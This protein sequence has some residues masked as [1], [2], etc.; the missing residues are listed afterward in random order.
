[1]TITHTSLQIEIDEILTEINKLSQSDFI[2]KYVKNP[3]I[4]VLGLQL[5]NLSLSESSIPKPIR[6][7][8]S[9][10]AGLVQLGID[11]HEKIT[12]LEEKTEYGIR[13][14]QL[15]IL[16]GDYYSS[17]YY[18][19]LAKNNLTDETKKLALA[20]RNI[21]IAK[22]KLY[23]TDSDN[24]FIS[25]D[26]IIELIMI[27][28]SNLYTQFLDEIKDLAQKEVWKSL[29]ENII[30]LFTLTEELKEKNIDKKHLSYH[31]IRNYSN[32]EEKRE[33]SN[34][35]L[36]NELKNH[37]IK[38]LYHKYD[39]QGKLEG[40]I[41]NINNELNKKI[42]IIEDRVIQRELLFILDKLSNS[43]ILKAV[44]KV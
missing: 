25:I 11:L 30:L 7:I 8:Y 36:N 37:K 32:L 24:K 14:R 23:T 16:A 28:E 17:Q 39:I 27:R 34:Y 26:Q 31:L 3:E 43:Y 10:T 18:S 2:G 12:N 33:L 22:M 44:E 19:L 42:R 21:N 4:S 29:I 41:I 13:K 6:K 38:Y 1:M 35:L 20:I 40:I 15:S 9:I 5:L